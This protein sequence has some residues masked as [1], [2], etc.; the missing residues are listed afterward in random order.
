[1]ILDYR[2]QNFTPQEL[3]D[4]F[5]SSMD[6]FSESIIGLKNSECGMNRNAYH[7]YVKRLY[8]LCYAIGRVDEK[9]GKKALQ[10]VNDLTG[11]I[12]SMLEISPLT[13]YVYK[14]GVM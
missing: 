7:S 8:D 6:Y 11:C 2:F 1:M 14:G 12:K 3:N 5:K 10:Q 4:N 13:K 9:C